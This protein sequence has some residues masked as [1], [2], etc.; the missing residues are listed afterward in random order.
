MRI[1]RRKLVS[2]IATVGVAA[3]GVAIAASPSARAA[4]TAVTRR[5]MFLANRAI[6]GPPPTRVTITV[7]PSQVIRQISPLIYGVSVASPE[8]LAALGA[9][10]NRWG[11]N[12]NTR[13]NWVLGDAWNSARDWEFRNYGGANPGEVV[14]ESASDR[15]IAA[16]RALAVETALTVPAIGWVARDGNSET[17]SLGVPDAGGPPITAGSDAIA[18][19][20]PADNRQRT[21]VPSFAAKG[22]P[23]VDPPGTQ[24]G[25]V[26]QDEW[27]YH[28][29]KHFGSAREGGV[30][31][32]I[33]DNEQDLWAS[34]H[35]D[36]YPVQPTYDDM[37]TTFLTYAS[38]IKTV[39]PEARVAGPALSGWTAYFFSARDQS[40]DRYRTHS[41]RQAHGDMP[42]LPW[43]LDQVRKYDESLGRRTLDVLDVHF[44]PQAQG[45]YGDAADLQTAA[46]RLRSTR[47]LWDPA[48]VDESWIAEPVRLIPRLREWVD[49]YYPGTRLALGE[50]NWGGEQSISGAL[51][52]ADVLGIFGREGLD[53]ASYWV[54]PP[55]G[56]PA[57]RAFALYTGSFGDLAVSAGAD[58]SPDYVTAYASKVSIAGDVVLIVINKMADAEIAATIRINGLNGG[59]A[60]VSRF[61][62]S[63]STLRPAGATE[64]RRSDIPLV[65]EASSITLV[66]VRGEQFVGAASG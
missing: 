44:Y 36:I 45:V 66:R 37:L 47:A 5:W 11:G 38:A 4:A 65:L 21:S 13:Y 49:Q 41:D 24:D 58:A 28:L 34:T 29:V 3:S 43:W 62:P 55:I 31:F 19:Y 15:F 7:N 50:W 32:F 42:F 18:G 17:R 22:A 48:Y 52:V 51:A 23:F 54:A 59:A 60:D 40:N 12:P 33:I 2:A 16:N 14:L 6:A 64:A 57:A 61:G 8:T 9:R 46:L 25:R 30:R 10:L 26:F 1:S 56:S 35:T 20:D 39:D 63:D 53:M 27:V